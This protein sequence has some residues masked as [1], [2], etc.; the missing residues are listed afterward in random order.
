[1]GEFSSI[2]SLVNLSQRLERNLRVIRRE[3]DVMSGQALIY[4]VELEDLVAQ[5]DEA[6]NWQP[7]SKA[8][9]AQR[10]NL[11]QDLNQLYQQQLRRDVSQIA[12][13]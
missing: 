6:I 13:L 8:L 4:Q 11:L 3:V 1:M 2:D 9:W 7:E 5:L 12:S 10:V